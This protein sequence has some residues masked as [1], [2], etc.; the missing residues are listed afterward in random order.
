MDLGAS[1]KDSN[2]IVSINLK[3]F[4]DFKNYKLFNSN[5]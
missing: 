2:D 5:I 3:T 1:P 4:I